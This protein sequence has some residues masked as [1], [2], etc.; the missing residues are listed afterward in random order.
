MDQKLDFSPGDK[1]DIGKTATLELTPKQTELITLAVKMGDLSLVLRSLQG[2]NDEARETPV[3][4]NAAAEPG[5]S[6]TEDSQVSKLIRPA[7]P[8]QATRPAVF[9]LRGSTRNKLDIDGSGGDA[10]GDSGSKPGDNKTNKTVFTPM[11]Q[12]EQQ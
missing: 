3:E 5:D 7:P 8:P 4:E 6:L 12:S 11:S 2:A 1:P 10:P 9:V